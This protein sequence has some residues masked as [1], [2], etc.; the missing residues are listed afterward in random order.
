MTN[1]QRE[2]GRAVRTGTVGIERDEVLAIR[3]HRAEHTEAGRDGLTQ[4]AS[5]Q[6]ATRDGRG[7]APLH[8]SGGVQGLRAIERDAGDVR[9]RVDADWRTELEHDFGDRMII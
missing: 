9:G 2:P 1:V 4:A 8:A 3:R 6:S 7:A 5:L